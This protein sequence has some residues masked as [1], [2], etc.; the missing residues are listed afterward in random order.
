M[1]KTKI[2]WVKNPDGTQ[3]Y[4]WNPIKGI[5][6]VG[7]WYCYAK[8]FYRRFKI[9]TETP[10]LDHREFGF[11]IKKPRGIFVCST[12]ELFHP[13]TKKTKASNGTSW[14]DIIFYAIEHSPNQRFYI[15][16]K[17]PQNIDRKM[18]SNVW[19]GVSVES[20][21]QFWRAQKLYLKHDGFKFISFEPLMGDV[22]VKECD[23]P[24]VAGEF[25]LIIVGRLTG[26][27]KKHD[28]EKGWILDIAGVCRDFNVPVFLKDNLKKIWGPNLIQEVPDV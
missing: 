14:R 15:L 24:D 17:L 8:G 1:Q 11:T 26:H 7:C 4:S 3:G 21:N 16:T 12:F 23:F 22:V 18:P 28:P 5:C 20:K 13:I 9:G 2:E 25:D 19:L 6:P 10:W 27:G